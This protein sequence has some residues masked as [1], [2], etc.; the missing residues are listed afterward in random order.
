MVYIGVI[1][2]LLTFYILLLTS[3]DIQ[4]GRVMNVPSFCVFCRGFLA[5]A[6]QCEGFGSTIRSLKCFP[7]GCGE[8]SCSMATHV[9]FMFRGYNPYEPRKK[10]WLVGLYRLLYCPVIWGVQKKKTLERSLLNNQDSMERIG[11][12]FHGSYF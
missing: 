8:S 6:A 2:H 1:T 4:V 7:F 11:G 12:F 9:S 10:T 5:G 3:W